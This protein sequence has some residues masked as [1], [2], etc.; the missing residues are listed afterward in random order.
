MFRDKLQALID[1]K[2]AAGQDRIAAMSEL[3]EQID[4]TVL[5]LAKMLDTG[6]GV[7]RQART[8]EDWYSNENILKHY[9]DRRSPE[10][11]RMLEDEEKYMPD[12]SGF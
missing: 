3:A 12:I 10:Q 7:P 6:S 1:R 5:E 2:V 11:L 9:R 4:L 8:V